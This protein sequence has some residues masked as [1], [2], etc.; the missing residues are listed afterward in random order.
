MF[1][2]AEPIDFGD[3]DPILL[4]FA[5]GWLEGHRINHYRP[6]N[7]WT[8]YAPDHRVS[9]VNNAALESADGVVAF[10]PNVQTVGVPA[11]IAQALTDE[12]PTLIVT[13]HNSS[14]VVEGWKAHP[15]AKV[16]G[17]G[18]DAID[19]GLNWLVDRSA[20][21]QRWHEEYDR[22]GAKLPDDVLTLPMAFEPVSDPSV[23]KDTG[24]VRSSNTGP[25]SYLPTRGYSDDAGFDLYVSATTSIPP[26]KFVDVHC[27]V[28][29]DLPM[30][31]W[32]LITGRSSSL[33]KHGLLVSN[34]IIDT[35]YTGPLFAGVQNLT[36]HEVVVN[37]GDRLAQLILLPALANQYHPTWGKVPDKPRGERGFGSTGC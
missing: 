4:D 10:L 27:G 6:K 15:F 36:D 5:Q 25:I 19:K 32:G 33:R 26:G 21:Q 14:F 2:I 30:G 28:K 34:G 29:A 7:A 22:V 13:N 16:V 1:Y 23:K 24:P 12:I 9:T 17:F 18:R 11:E 37:A 20:E 3:A 31:V 35:G 8:A